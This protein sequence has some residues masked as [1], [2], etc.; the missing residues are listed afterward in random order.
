[1]YWSRK[2]TQSPRDVFKSSSHMYWF[3]CDLC[4][5]EFEMSPGKI[6]C[7]DKW[8][9]YCGGKKLCEDE[10]CDKCLSRS[11]QSHPKAV[12]WSSK[13]TISPRHIFKGSNQVYWFKCDQCTHEF[14]TRAS[15]VSSGHW[16]PYCA[17][18]KLCENEA[19]EECLNRSF[20]SQ[21]KSMYWSSRNT[22][23]PRSV[24]RSSD[25]KYWFNCNLCGHEFLISLHDITSHY[26]WCQFC[27]NKTETK[28]YDY[29]IIHHPTL[30]RQFRP[31]WCLDSNT[32]NHLVFDFVIEEYKI[33]IEL[34]GNQHFE[35]IL[36]WKPYEKTQQRDMY[37]MLCA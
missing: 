28:L 4:K 11:F 1:M 37:K 3:T 22:I 9:P 15:I 25:E 24:S 31:E 33:I 23:S 36:N 14:Q 26:T 10:T 21:P 18:Q 30:G 16:C 17:N 32:Q 5:H 2:N 13:N 19:C 6:T 20:Q 27:T 35:Q 8:C 7:E 34:D 12:Y 29:L